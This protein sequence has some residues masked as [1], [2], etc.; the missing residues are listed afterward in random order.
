MDFLLVHGSTQSPGSWG[1]LAE[2]LTARGHRVVAVDLPVDTPELRAADYAAI[3]ADQAAGLDQPVAVAHSLGGVLLPA[4]AE[5]VRARHLVWLAA[6]L[7][8]IAGGRSVLDMIA[9]DSAQMFTPEWHTWQEDVVSAPAISAYFLFHDCDVATLRWVLPYLRLFQPRAALVEPPP[10][11]PSA[12]STFVVPDEDRTLR[13]DWMR[14]AAVQ[15]LG[16]T[17]V[18][19]PGGHCP[20][21]SQPDR[22]AD[23]LHS[24]R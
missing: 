24:V 2:L 15:R 19:V 23:L 7:P 17:V 20:Q 6:L 16:A 13:P 8:D 21:V 4:I 11:A 1:R 18:D 3:A 10:A 12:P 5:A 22:I 14:A 9:A